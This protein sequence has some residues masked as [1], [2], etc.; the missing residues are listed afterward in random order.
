MA[1]ARVLPSSRTSS[2]TSESRC[3]S[4]TPAAARGRGPAASGRV[5]AHCC[6]PRR[7]RRPRR[8]RRLA[9]DSGKVLTTSTGV[10]RV[11]PLEGAA[12]D[13]LDPCAVDEVASL[14]RAV[15]RPAP[16]PRSRS[17]PGRPTRRPAARR[18]DGD[19]QSRSAR[20][21]TDVLAALDVK[22]PRDDAV[23]QLE[24]RASRVGEVAADD[25]VGRR[26]GHGRALHVDAVL[27]GPEPVRVVARP[28]RP[29]MGLRGRR[30]P[31]A[32]RCR[33][34]RRAPAP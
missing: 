2:S 24:D 7:P 11:A 10:G 4:S 13:R 34:A 27:V 15:T 20:A 22:A 25:H 5:S 17:L 8:R 19:L 9:S 26:A 16:L 28:R 18:V 29:S 12:G 30:G 6:Q 1:S 32:G 23:A 31:A 21:P 33:R 3:R 14:V